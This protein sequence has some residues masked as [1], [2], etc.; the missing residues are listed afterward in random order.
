MDRDRF[1]L[2]L[3]SI[4]PLVDALRQGDTVRVGL[5]LSHALALNRRFGALPE[6]RL[7]PGAPAPLLALGLAALAHDRGCLPEITV[8][9]PERRLVMG[10]FP[11]ETSAVTLCFPLRR[12]RSP[13]EAHWF[14]DIRGIPAERG[15]VV[16][17]DPEGRLLAVYQGKGPPPAPRMEARFVLPELEHEGSSGPIDGSLPLA[18]DPG[19]LVAYAEQILNFSPILES[20]SGLRQQRQKLVDAIGA[21]GLAIEQIAPGIEAILPA[22]LVSAVGQR[23][24]QAEPGRFRRDRLSAYRSGLQKSLQKLDQQITHP[25]STLETPPPP[26]PPAPEADARRHAL[27]FVETIRAQVTPVI[28]ALL[29][30]PNRE[31]MLRIKPR[32]EDY[33]KVFVAEAR[34]AARASYETLW[35][36]NM[37]LGA[38][39]S[40]SSRLVIHISPAGMLAGENELSHHFP[41]G[42]R[43]LAKWLQPQRTWVAWKVI[44]PGKASGMSYDGLVWCDDHWAWFPKPYRVLQSWL[45]AQPAGN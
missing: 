39:V 7:D 10:D 5:S 14:L 27:Q 28:Y 12:I 22:Q 11:K 6:Y 37:D 19:E 45:A 3:M 15:H 20:L 24:Y 2:L 25:G 31:A 33:E 1:D 44:E 17:V 42:Y 29:S 30:H 36:S 18:L 43:G 34:P 21:I 38:P 23:L 8:E 4:P 32:D 26:A 13:A 35:S 9:A 41:G 40:P 16:G